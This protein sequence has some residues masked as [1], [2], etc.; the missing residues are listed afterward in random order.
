M[1]P[2]EMG[3]FDSHR[4]HWPVL[5]CTEGVQLSS[6]FGGDGLNVWPVRAFS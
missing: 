5:V 1:L 3:D 6:M 2:R 4:K